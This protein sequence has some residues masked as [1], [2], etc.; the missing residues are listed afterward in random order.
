MHRRRT[1]KVYQS[2]VGKDEACHIFLALCEHYI[3]W[4]SLLKHPAC[5]S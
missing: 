4:R 3:S 2:P 1:L 5:M